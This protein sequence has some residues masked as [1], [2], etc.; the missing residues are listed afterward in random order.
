MK[1]DHEEST[2][3]NF[4][5]LIL[6]ALNARPELFSSNFWEP[7]VR[8]VLALLNSSSYPMSVFSVLNMAHTFLH[9]KVHEPYQNVML[10]GYSADDQQSGR[11]VFSTDN[12]MSLGKVS[13]DF[14]IMYHLE[15]KRIQYLNKLNETRMNLMPLL[16]ERCM[17]CP[18]SLSY[19]V[20]FFCE[21]Y[22]LYF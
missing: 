13:T 9:T 14:V 1:W 18:Y 15:Q 20:H 16:N 2:W 6:H 22:F 5:F 10:V 21:F 17:H 3:L 12:V 4:C 8:S 11:N 7:D 19:F